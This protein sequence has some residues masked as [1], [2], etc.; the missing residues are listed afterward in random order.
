[1]NRIK[2]LLVHATMTSLVALV[3]MFGPSTAFA[4][5]GSPITVGGGGGAP[6]LNVA[7]D[8]SPIT[9]GGGGGA[10]ADGDSPITVGGGGSLFLLIGLASI[11]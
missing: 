7:P 4:G 5:D 8:D 6:Q 2:K 10:S 9:V 11:I 1:M 3:L